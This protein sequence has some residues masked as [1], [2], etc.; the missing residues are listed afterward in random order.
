MDEPLLGI[1]T[2]GGNKGLFAEVKDQLT[3][4]DPQQEAADKAAAEAQAAADEAAAA[5]VAADQAANDQ[6]A[7][8]L[9]A[10][11]VASAQASAE[12]AEAAAEAEDKAA[13]QALAAKH[14]AEKRRDEAAKAAKKAEKER[15][16]YTVKAGDTLSA[17]AKKY[18]VHSMDI[19]KENHKEPR[20]D[21][22]GTDLRHS[23][24]SIR[25]GQL[26]GRGRPT[27]HRVGRP[28][29]PTRVAQAALV[30]SGRG[31]PRAG[32]GK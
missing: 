4:H 8:D 28:R 18:G 1:P 23:G 14:Q 31:L 17:I 27:Q 24:L 30:A 13:A 16:T 21:L 12:Q 15:R 3:G 19:A 11:Q 6:A 20:P 2:D 7:A 29:R 9:A 26:A 5:Q 25:R 32:Q 10:A 22:P